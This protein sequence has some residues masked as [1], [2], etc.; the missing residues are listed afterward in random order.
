MKWTEDEVLSR[1]EEVGGGD[2]WR[3]VRKVVFEIGDLA[4]FYG[5]LRG[6]GLLEIISKET[7]WNCVLEFRKII[8]VL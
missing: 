3:I 7:S 4:R 6:W 1:I 5:I 2:C 8:I